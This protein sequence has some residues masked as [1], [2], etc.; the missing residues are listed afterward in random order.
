MEA[1]IIINHANT[2]PSLPKSLELVGKKVQRL[3]L[4][5]E[6]LNNVH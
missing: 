3:G 5:E 4:R 6:I 1:K 2:E